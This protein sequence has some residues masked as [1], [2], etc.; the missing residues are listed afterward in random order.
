M[1]FD[2]SIVYM[3][4]VIAN[5]PF[6]RRALGRQDNNNNILPPVLGHHLLQAARSPR[7]ISVS[8]PG[9]PARSVHG[10]FLCEQTDNHR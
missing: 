4:V 1:Q 8:L 6:R 7:H 2:F 9:V 10:E 5:C 3:C